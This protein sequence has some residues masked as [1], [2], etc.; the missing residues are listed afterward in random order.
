MAVVKAD[1]YGHGMLEVARTALDWGCGWLGAGDVREG[2]AL[3]QAGLESPC[4]ILAPLFGGEEEVAVAAGLVPTV[5]DAGSAAAISHAAVRLGQPADVHL[6]VDTGLGR[7]GVAP[8]RLPALARAV[9]KMPGLRIQGLYTHF[10]QPLD[11][12][13]TRAELREF[14]AACEA[15]QGELGPVPLLHAAGSEAAVTVPESRLGLVRLGNLMYGLWAGPR[16]KLPLLDGRTV[17][18]V[19]SLR[20]RVIAL[21]DFGAGDRLGYGS[22]RAKGT[23]RV[24]VLPVGVSDGISLRSVQAG[25]GPWVVMG[26][27]VRETARSV[28]PAYRPQARING[29]GAPLVGRVGMQFTLVDVTGLPDVSVGDVVMVPAVRATAARN[30][31]RV[32]RS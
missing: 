16:R 7:F 26:T 2:V 10:A 29:R 12:A 8:Q 14:L 21:R 13:R 18:P 30:L 17:K 20:T 3:R 11:V 4:L 6:L 9:A 32:F 23:M 5:A 31:P 24:A 27:L 22:Y 15:V 19:W 25:A 1:A 28:L